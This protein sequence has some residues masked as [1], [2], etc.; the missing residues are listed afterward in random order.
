MRTP[1]PRVGVA[2]VFSQLAAALVA[3]YAV[4][5]LAQRLVDGCVELLDVWAAGLLLSDPASTPKLLAASTHEAALLELVQVR[6]G[7]GPCLAAME[8]DAVVVVDDLSEVEEQW[9]DWVAAARELGIEQA[10]GVPLVHQG[11]TVGAL[12]LFRRSGGS[13]LA[14][15]LK[16][17]SAMADVVTV[18]ILQHRALENAAGVTAQ[19]QRALDSRVVIEQAKG[20]LAERAGISVDEAF[21]R[22][23]QHARS[24]SQPIGEVARA[25]V[26]EGVE[27]GAADAALRVGSGPVP[28]RAAADD[29]VPDPDDGRLSA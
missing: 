18:G 22:L 2:E 12:N 24:T 3:P 23:R 21:G 4:T 15:D 7:Q 8:R 10:Y 9:P 1:D 13:L 26:E 5:D 11:R 29:D 17:A 25:L 16:V 6:S 14:D 27:P 19:L 20:L 28:R